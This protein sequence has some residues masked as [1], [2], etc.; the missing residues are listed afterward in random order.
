MEERGNIIEG[1]ACDQTDLAKVNV[2]NLA[3]DQEEYLIIA[4]VVGGIIAVVI[5]ILRL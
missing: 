1:A 4:A 2:D 5:V 3:C